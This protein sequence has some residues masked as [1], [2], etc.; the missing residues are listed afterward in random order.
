MS[1][2]PD[3]FLTPEQYL[4]IERKAATR[5][6]YFRG[7]MFAM[8]GAR[9]R[10]NLI[11]DNF[12]REVGIQLKGGTC[13]VVTSDQRVKIPATGLYTYPDIVVVCGEPQFEDRTLDT[14]L[15]PTIIVEVLSESTEN[16]DR[17]TKFKHYRQL[18]SVQEYV[19]VSQDQALMERYTR[20][21][22]NNW[23]IRFFSD[24]MATFEF[25]S[26]PVSVPLSEIYSGVRFDVPEATDGVEN[27]RPA[28]EP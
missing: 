20:Q 10:H 19:L 18:A 26:I 12:A 16:Y 3:K 28:T 6:E 21:P 9:W 13:R 23:L 5:S 24:L 1:T 27:D 17:V 2:V 22:D 7:E 11:K 25:S 14:L 15:N 8:S 4:A